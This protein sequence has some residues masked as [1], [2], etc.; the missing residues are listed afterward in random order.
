[1][2]AGTFSA[3]A[4]GVLQAVTEV[5]PSSFIFEWCGYKPA[6][7]NPRLLSFGML[8]PILSKPMKPIAFMIADI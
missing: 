4:A 5:W 8:R 6:G 2:M 1:M 3:A 7:D